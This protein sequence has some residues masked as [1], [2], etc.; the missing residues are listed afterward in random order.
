MAA[1]G[2]RPGRPPRGGQVARPR[3][4]HSS[5]ESSALRKG[6][7]HVC[8]H[9]GPGRRGKPPN[10]PAAAARAGSLRPA[11]AAAGRPV[12]RKASGP[13]RRPPPFW[14]FPDTLLGFSCF[15]LRPPPPRF[16]F[17]GTFWEG[18]AS[19]WDPLG[20]PAGSPAL[21]AGPTG[22]LRCSLAPLF[23]A[24][25]PQP[26][27]GTPRRLGGSRPC[28]AGWGAWA[29][30]SSPQHSL[31]ETP[32]VHTGLPEPLW[33]HTPCPPRRPQWERDPQSSPGGWRGWAGGGGCAEGSGRGPG[34]AGA[35]A[36]GRARLEPRS[37]VTAP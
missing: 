30:A 36:G 33:G 7:V 31:S 28:V 18:P 9:R 32:R 37:W 2:G 19:V 23:P 35:S 4:R 15:S 16:M 26:S 25:G 17:S 5:P 22:L 11:G 3:R 14:G 10:R 6:V 20:A 8:G 13:S 27:A 21:G 12:G 24:T 29:A 34:A 1:P